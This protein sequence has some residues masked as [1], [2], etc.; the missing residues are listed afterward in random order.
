VLS[1]LIAQ[2][3]PTYFL[4]KNS[5]ALAKLTDSYLRL[6]ASGGVISRALCDTALST[7]LTLDRSKPAPR[8]PVS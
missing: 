5:D 6:L 8:A 4:Q 3:A 7:Q 2:R 1:L